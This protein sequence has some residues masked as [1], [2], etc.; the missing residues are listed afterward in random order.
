MCI[1]V[2]KPTGI[3]LP[4]EEIFDNCFSSNRDGIGFSYALPNGE[5]SISKGYANVKKLFKMFSAH[6]ITKKHNLIVHFRFATHGKKD[7]GNCHPFPLSPSFD[8]MRLLNCTCGTAI[9]H[10]GVFSGMPAHKDHSDT[11]KFIGGIL[12]QPEII[13]NL[14]SKAVKELIR[15]YCGYSSKLAFLRPSGLKLIGDFEMDENVYYSNTQYKKWNY[16]NYNDYDYEKTWCHVHKVKDDCAYCQT[17]KTWDDCSHNRITGWKN[18]FVDDPVLIDK[19]CDN[20]CLL[21]QGK[22]KVMWNEEADGWLCDNCELLYSGQ[23]NG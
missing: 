17:H 6:G 15:G 9:A 14:D 10:N 5:V 4:S 23:S 11:M 18:R 12:A 8:D 21:C 13:D 1:I 20:V 19:C 3:D 2:A 7:P 22:K 16:K